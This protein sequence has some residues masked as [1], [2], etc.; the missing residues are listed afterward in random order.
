MQAKTINKSKMI[1]R[2]P[3]RP[4]TSPLSQNELV[5]LRMRRL[6]NR[7][8]KYMDLVPVEVW[9]EKAQR[10]IL[11]RM[12]PNDLSA[13]ATQAFALLIKERKW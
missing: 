4:K 2:G 1:R 6:R 11:L 3:G 5:K 9:I 13:A 12:Y 10:D 7:K 8:R